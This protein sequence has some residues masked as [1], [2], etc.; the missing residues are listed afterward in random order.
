MPV[1]GDAGRLQGREPD[2]AARRARPARRRWRE[3]ELERLGLIV[4]VDTRDADEPE[5]TVIG[6]DPAPG[7]ELLRGD[8]GDDRRLDRRRLGDRARRRGPVRGRGAIDTLQPRASRSTW[9]RGDRGAGEDGRV[10]DQAPSAGARVRSG[11]TVTIVVGEL[12]RARADAEPPT[13]TDQTTSTTAH[14][15]P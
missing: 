12:H 13:P 6:Q 10:L 14:E 15:T 3:S 1:D 9:S 7:S 8:R 2:H 5:G 4:D 11:D